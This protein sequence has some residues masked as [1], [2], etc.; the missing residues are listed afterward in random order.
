LT[1][2][3]FRTPKTAGNYLL[4]LKKYGLL[5]TVKLGKEKLYLN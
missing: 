2:A 5:K 1:D 3:K 4:A